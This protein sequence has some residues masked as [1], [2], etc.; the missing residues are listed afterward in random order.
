MKIFLRIIYVTIA[1]LVVIVGYKAY[2]IYSARKQAEK[3]PQEQIFGSENADLTVVM[4]IDYQCP[5][6]KDI[7]PTI[8]NAIEEDGNARL[9]IHL[10]PAMGEESDR[11]GRLAYAA[12][13][14]GKFREVHDLLIR[15][16]GP[17]DNSDLNRVAQETGLDVEKWLADSESEKIRAIMKTNIELARKLGVYATPTFLSGNIIYVPVEKL[18]EESDFRRLFAEG[19]KG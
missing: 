11:I 9:V 19:R 8:L 1:I 2:G 10:L 17:F 12:G 13:L 18:P 15:H 5:Y 3:A 14:Q 16:Y 4:F 7:Y 6:C